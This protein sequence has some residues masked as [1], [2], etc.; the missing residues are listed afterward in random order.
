MQL[1]IGYLLATLLGLVTYGAIFVRILARRGVFHTLRSAP[2]AVPIR[3]VLTFSVPLLTN[4]GVWLLVNTLPLIVLT[5]SRGL[6]EVAA[7]Q[8]IRPAAALN[9]IVANSFYVLYLP[10]AS[11]IAARRDQAASGELFWRTT[12]WVAVMSFPI[13]A[14]TFALGRPIS[15]LLFGDRYEPSGTYLSILAVGYLI[16][17][18]SGFNG[19]TLAANGHTRTVAIVNLVSALVGVALAL[20]LIPIG[21]ALGAATAAALTLILQSLTLQVALWRMLGIPL[22]DRE[23]LRVFAIEGAAIAVLV[24][25]QSVVTFGWWTIVA[26]GLVSLGVLFLCR[27][28]L[29]VDTLFPEVGVIMARVSRILPLRRTG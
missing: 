25:I 10:A 8:V 12:M 20:V 5:A 26:V 14:G 3:E 6:E 17:A 24:A 13:F 22:I 19:V 21:G 15:G 18:A 7:F 2:P 29:R 23:A 1:A 28:A 4:D 11:R 9:M 27:D 16:N